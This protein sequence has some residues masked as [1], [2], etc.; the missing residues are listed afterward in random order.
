M[1]KMFFIK[2]NVY[3]RPSW[4]PTGPPKKTP[5]NVQKYPFLKT[6][7]GGIPKVDRK[8]GMKYVYVTYETRIPMCFRKKFPP[9]KCRGGQ[10]PKRYNSAPSCTPPKKG[11]Y[12]SAATLT[13]PGFFMM[14]FLDR[15]MANSHSLKSYLMRKCHLT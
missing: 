15:T 9:P 7:W 3:P 4:T 5:K 12:N 2:K 1:P 11:R 6:L 8:S 10:K 14:F 13:P